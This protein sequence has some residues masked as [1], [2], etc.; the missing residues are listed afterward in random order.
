MPTRTILALAPLALRL[1]LA[2]VEAYRA[3]GDAWREA[4]ALETLARTGTT[5][6]DRLVAR[7]HYRHVVEATLG[8]ARAALESWAVS[9]C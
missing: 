9:A 1:S 4:A 7:R 2:R 8:P 5:L 3:V 6:Q